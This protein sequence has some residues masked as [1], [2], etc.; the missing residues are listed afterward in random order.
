MNNILRKRWVYLDLVCL[1]FLQPN[2]GK[3]RRPQVCSLNSSCAEKVEAIDTHLHHRVSLATASGKSCTFWPPAYQMNTIHA[4]SPADEVLSLFS[5]RLSGPSPLLWILT[6]T[7]TPTNYIL[8]HNG[9][10]QVSPPSLCLH[11]RYGQHLLKGAYSPAQNESLCKC[12]TQS[13]TCTHTG[14]W[15]HR[16]KVHTYTQKQQ[17][18]TEYQFALPCQKMTHALILLRGYPRCWMCSVSKQESK[19][20]ELLW[21]CIVCSIRCVSVCRPLFALQS[22]SLFCLDV[23]YVPHSWNCEL[24]WR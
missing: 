1:F 11:K 18:R 8:Q 14:S 17:T 24:L 4:I 20:I 19:V 6:R 7:L 23:Q 3:R 21:P 2:I 9:T 10:L 16:Q 13:H 15:G 12:Q 22:T 5:A